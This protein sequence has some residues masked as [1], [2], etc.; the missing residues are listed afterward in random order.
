MKCKLPNELNEK[1]CTLVK[2]NSR[3]YFP[4]ILYNKLSNLFLQVLNLYRKPTLRASISIFD[5]D[6]QRAKILLD[7][8]HTRTIIN[9]K[10]F[11]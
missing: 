11:P 7:I 10:N 4:L 8:I 2:I 5:I 9:A 1:H 3:S 6:R